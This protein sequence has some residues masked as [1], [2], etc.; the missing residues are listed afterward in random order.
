M[1]F[2]AV[3]LA[4]SVVGEGRAQQR[5]EIGHFRAR[6]IIECAPG[7]GPGAPIAIIVPGTGGHGPE[8]AMPGSITLDGKETEI[9]TSLA[10]GMRK[11]GIHTLQLGKPGI[12]FH[13]TW[14]M[15]KI[16]YDKDMFLGLTWNDLI[17]NTNDGIAYVSEQ[18]PCGAST[19]VLAGHSEGTMRIT[20][21]AAVNPK[22]RGLVF[23]GFH[24]TGFRDIVDWQAYQRPIDLL[25]KTDIDAD[26]DGF[27]TKDEG[28]RWPTDFT[29]PWKPD[30]SR[31][32]IPD[33]QAHL[34]ANPD[35]IK[36]IDGLSKAPLYSNGI[37]E[38]TPTYSSLARMTIP[39]VAFTGTLDVY[40]PPREV[41]ALKAACDQAGKKDCEIHLIP[42][43]GHG[44]SA[45]KPPRAHPLLD[46]TEGPLD[47]RFLEL[48]TGAL[49][50]WRARIRP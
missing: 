15:E 10:A 43:L 23:M 47:P 21:V 4:F 8:E 44:M 27:V 7:A 1:R 36:A 18:R 35:Y 28:A 22:V 29:Y 20:D 48:F 11:A 45:P 2:L 41:E 12:E 31:I 50:K 3:V 38:R 30:Q 6:A 19:V 37:W 17:T 16:A 9:L 34:R 24:G 5:V 40:T 13:T 42:G 26:H 14:D 39:I 32:S 46:K 49:E 33:Y 25:V